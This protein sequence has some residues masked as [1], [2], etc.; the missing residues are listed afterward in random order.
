MGDLGF[1]G[2]SQR[3]FAKSTTA[4]LPGF[5][6]LSGILTDRE[7][8]EF[9]GEM[10]QAESVVLWQSKVSHVTSRISCSNICM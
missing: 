6:M 9:S 1:C 4:D 5:S 10:D 7:V 2:R 3:C 8:R